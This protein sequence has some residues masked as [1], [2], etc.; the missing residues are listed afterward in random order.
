MVE[1]CLPGTGGMLPTETRWTAS[2]WVEYQGHAI[3]IDCG[4]GTQIALKKA[5]CRLSR[6]ELILITHFHADHIMGLPGLLLTLGNY[7]KTTPLIIA[8]P[9]GLRQVLDSLMIIAP[10]L[11]FDVFLRELPEERQTFE[12]FG[13]R[14]SSMGLQ[15]RMP[16]LGYRIDFLRKPIFNPE[17]AKALGVPL[18]H[19]KTLHAG[20]SVVLQGGKRIL[21]EMVLDGERRPISIC[22]C[23]DTQPFDEISD[24]ALGADLFICE[25]MHG[26]T[27]LRETTWEKGHMV[28][29]DS[30]QLAKAARVKALWLTHF[31][32]ALT[33]P[34]QYLDATASI[35]SNTTIGLDGIKTTLK[36]I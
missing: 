36:G 11:P 34:E 3:L 24:F 7:G 26:D 9:V 12:R 29:A 10:Q 16:C 17:K 22:Y 8:G 20:Q 27:L 30:A 31:S 19:Y 2:C 21:P 28:F 4:E 35:F 1:V 13:I 6:L 23:T 15:H 14:F 32:P 5:D 25:G 33:Q 18:Q